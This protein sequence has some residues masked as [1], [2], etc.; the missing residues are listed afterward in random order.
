VTFTVRIDGASTAMTCTIPQNGS[1]CTD[2]IHAHSLHA[3]DTLDIQV[4]S[5]FLVGLP[6]V[7]WA[8]NLS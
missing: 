4:Q 2:T 8:T 7:S 3:G 5:S 6:V 1:S